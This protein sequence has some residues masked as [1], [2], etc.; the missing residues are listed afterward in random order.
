MRCRL[1]SLALSRIGGFLGQKGAD[2][3]LDQEITQHLAM[4]ADR[5][6]QQGLSP[7]EAWRAA[8]RQFGGV[9][10]MKESIRERR[11]LP[12]VEELIQDGRYALRQLRKAFGFTIVAVSV[13]ALGVGANTAI[14]SVINAV[15][16]RPLPYPEANRLV[17]IGE[18]LKGNSTDEVTLTPDVLE[19][20]DHSEAF[21]GMAAF[22]LV[23]RTLTKVGEP[24]QLQTAKAST[25]LSVLKVQPVLG[26]N[27]TQKEDR[28]G[29][30]QVALISYGLWQRNFGGE[31]SV[32][33]RAITLDDRVYTVIGVLPRSFYFPSSV[34]I[35][36]ITPLGKNEEKEMKR[37]SGM[38][39]VHDVIARM[40]P[41]VTLNQARAQMEIIESHIAPPSFMSGLQM[42]VR[43]MSLRSQFVGSL[44][45][46]LFALLCAVG[47]LLLMG[48]ANLSNLLLSRAITRQREMAIRSSL[49]ASRLRLIKQLLMESIVLAVLGCAAGVVLAFCTRGILLRLLPRSIPGLESLSLDWRVL[50]FALV[51]ACLCAIVFGIGPAL[52]SSAAPIAQSLTADGRYIFAVAR[53]QLWLNAL[54]STQIAIAIVLLCGGGLMLRSFWNLRYRGLGFRTEHLL[55]AQLH[56]GKAKYADNAAQVSFIK[57]FIESARVLPGVEGIAV[58]NLPPGEGHASNGFGIE[59]R[60]MLPRGQKPVARAYAIS[61]AYLDVLQIPLLK[62]RG[63]SESD[64]AGTIPVALVSET[65]AHRNFPGQD[66][67]GRRL[68][69]ERD[70]PWSTIIGIVA[71]VRTAGL[72]FPPE[73]VIYFPYAQAGAM[74]EDVGILVR[75]A[76]NP[77]YIEP[78]LRRNI[79][80][81]D[82]QQPITDMQTMDQRLN[83]SVAKPRLATVLLG[84]FAVLGMTLATVGLY[85]VMSLLV[86]GRFWDI[87]IR[88]ALGARP[89]DVLRM[90]LTQSVQIIFIGIASGICCALLLTRLMQS[91]LYNVSASDPLTLGAVTGFLVLV[92]LTASYFP[93]RRASQIDPM[94]TL[95]VE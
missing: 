39:I 78:Q 79:A 12:P 56:L 26:R 40:K 74:D 20:R 60:A 28:K 46:S 32:L 43:I 34:S 33:G 53:R 88:L 3:D 91:L 82:L 7:E 5:F 93:A 42:T 75:S 37:S 86:R 36:V 62:G 89:H 92:A 30:D 17:W 25:L 23:R 41:D 70:D 1:L 90:V 24:L 95:R 71:D 65:F 87:G 19:W 48:C 49:G 6:L 58:G 76:V 15:L 84:C 11:G 73:S 83:E 8:R 45:R 55:T 80:R 66:A 29:S 35:D 59:G 67:L 22:N 68:R 69:L 51:S 61:P 31:R 85:G 57:Q 21:N 54:A 13:L 4:L 2:E 64:G 16:L 81:L 38:T 9:T 63:I 27:F 77:A 94:A 14:F 50:S 47:F 18:T 72:V 52:L 10:Q 44:R